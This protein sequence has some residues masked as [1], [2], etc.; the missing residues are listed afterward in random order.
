MSPP[1]W[2]LDARRHLHEPRRIGPSSVVWPRTDR[3]VR[4]GPS[5]SADPP[6]RHA[7]HGVRGFEAH[8]RPLQGR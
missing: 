1:R 3:S 4:A 7:L 6:T 5:R 8:S 2:Q